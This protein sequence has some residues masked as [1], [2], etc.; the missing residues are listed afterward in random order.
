MSCCPF[1]FSFSHT[2]GRPLPDGI[3]RLRLCE[4]CFALPPMP[5]FP[6]LKM[7]KFTNVG[8][9]PKSMPR[10]HYRHS[11]PVPLLTF[12]FSPDLWLVRHCSSPSAAAGGGRCAP[13]P[14]AEPQRVACGA[15]DWQCH[16]QPRSAFAPAMQR[17]LVCC[18]VWQPLFL[19]INIYIYI[20]IY[21]YLYIHI[22]IFPCTHIYVCK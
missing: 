21:I 10:G 5:S 6:S 3:F 2:V 1:L 14:R 11:T 18:T 9:S 4:G 16:R 15:A 19:S 13:L 17:V 7:L 20:Y 12:F 8:Q 22:C